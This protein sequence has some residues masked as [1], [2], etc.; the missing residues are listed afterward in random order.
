MTNDSFTIFYIIDLTFSK[1]KK[2]LKY[3]PIILI[4]VSICEEMRLKLLIRI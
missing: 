1:T 4:F 2:N 3:N